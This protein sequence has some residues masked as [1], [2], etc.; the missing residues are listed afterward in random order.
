MQVA[1]AIIERAMDS[2]APPGSPAPAGEPKR[3]IP[4][5]APAANQPK[6]ELI[7]VVIG[8]NYNLP[9]KV[10][11]KVRSGAD[12]IRENG[13]S[14]KAIFAAVLALDRAMCCWWTVLWTVRESGFILRGRLTCRSERRRPEYEIMLVQKL[15]PTTP[16]DRVF[17]VQLV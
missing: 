14:R 16:A 5:E 11:E 7:Q 12:R 2:G 17:W 9:I 1:L 6:G 3:S 8:F 13:P 15:H 4:G 10:A